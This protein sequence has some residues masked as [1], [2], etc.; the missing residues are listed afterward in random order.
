MSLMPWLET[1]L[2]SWLAGRERLHHAWLLTGVPGIGKAVLAREM[3]RSLLCEAPMANGRACGHCAACHWFDLGHHPDFRQLQPP[4]EENDKG[5]RKL[6]V[7]NIEAVRELA[8]FMGLTSHRGGRRVVLIDPADAL[9]VAAANGLLKTLEEPPANTVFLLV[10]QRLGALL[11]TVRSRCR[12]YAVPAPTPEQA[13]QWM[14]EN[15]HR[16]AAE[17]LAFAGG[18]PLA[19][20]EA[21]DEENAQPRLALLSLLAEPKRLDPLAEGRRLEKGGL[22]PVWMILTRWLADLAQV[23]AGGK[24]H[25]FP[26]QEISL[27]KLAKAVDLLT[28]FEYYRRL[29]GERGLLHHP[30]QAKL[31]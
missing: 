1:P 16:A 8:D 15:G 24:P 25:Y 31:M 22:E 23:A 19:A 11:P 5:K 13:L 6:P 21:F 12:Q 4:V 29:V 3:A 30:L 9:N 18:A 28:L 27:T 26:A 14:E 2:D 17:E 10:T 7:I 20:L